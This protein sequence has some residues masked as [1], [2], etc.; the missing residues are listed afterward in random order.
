[1]RVDAFDYE[2]PRELI[3]QAPARSRDAARLLVVGDGLSDR[4][5]LDLPSLLRPGDLLV[6]NDTQVIPTRLAGERGAARVEVTLHRELGDGRWAAFARPARR[7]RPGDRIQFSETLS[8]D[9]AE[10][11]QGGEVVLQFHLS[12]KALAAAL[13]ESG[14]MPV[15]PY[16]KRDR[17][18][19]ARDRQDYQTVFATVPGAVAAPTAGL[20]FTPR[21]LK[22]LED[23][24]IGRVSV[25]LHVGAGTFLPVTVEH[26]EEH[27][28]HAETGHVGAEA[29][30]AIN[31]TRRRGGRIVAVGSTALRILETASDAAGTVS[32]FDGETS[33]FITP[34]Y[35][36]KAIDLLITNFHLPRS[37]LFMMVA[38]F[39]GLERIHAA[40]EHA[41][42]EGY[43]FFSYG[44]ACLLTPQERR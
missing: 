33:I 25:T 44:D 22:S 42:R 36:F 41:K 19:D 6:V 17:G 30:D 10:R 4:G 38:A 18:G 35:R 29:A 32:P 15:P 34:G 14:A 11:G 21:L 27:R 39:A 31:D 28:M 13:D 23:A 8:A 1:M 16:I 3:A 20:H 24:G 7:L 9:V 40:Y 12:G 43:R 26:T 37:T 2:L 5:M